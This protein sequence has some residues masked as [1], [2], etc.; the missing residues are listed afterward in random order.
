MNHPATPV[1]TLTDKLVAQKDGGIGWIVFNNPARHNA[2][3]FE[4]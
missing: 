3:S 1:P 4:M 2:T